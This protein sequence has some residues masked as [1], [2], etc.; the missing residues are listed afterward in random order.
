MSIFFPI[1]ILRCYIC[2]LGKKIG[3]TKVLSGL[4]STKNKQNF[5]SR[6]TFGNNMRIVNISNFSRVNVIIMNYKKGS[7][8]SD[9]KGTGRYIIKTAYPQT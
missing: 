6:V 9:N 8:D 2:N 5:A 7:A 3:V 1:S 4:I